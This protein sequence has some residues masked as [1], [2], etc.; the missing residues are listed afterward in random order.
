MKTKTCFECETTE[1]LQ[2]HHV[3]PKSL[4]GTKTI[5]LC[6]QCHMKVHGR[7]GKGLDHSRLTKEGI[8]R[9]KAEGVKMGASKEDL[10]KAR[11]RGIEARKKK[12]K[13]YAKKLEQNI[14]TIIK[15]DS[16]KPKDVS[17]RKMCAKLNSRGITTS[18][19]NIF[20]HPTQIKESL[21]KIN[22]KLEDL[23]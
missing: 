21:E 15:E 13:D 5:T 23:T 7:D 22:L 8:A 1:D 14:R 11:A 6:Y 19:G 16:L 17:L 4:G 9:R 10:E 3:V 20:N 18:N 2:Q 12:A